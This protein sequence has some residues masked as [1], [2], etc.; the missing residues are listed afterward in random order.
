MTEE[1]KLSKKLRRFLNISY[2][3]AVE[4]TIK[5]GKLDVNSKDYRQ[6]DILSIVEHFEV[7]LDKRKSLL[8]GKDLLVLNCFLASLRNTV[9]N[10]RFTM[11]AT[12]F[13]ERLTDFIMYI[14]IWLNSE[15]NFNVD[16]KIESRRKSLE[17]ELTK[18]LV[19]SIEHVESNDIILST[20][21]PIIRDRYGLRIIM[22]DDNPKLLLEVTGIIISILTNPISEAHI[23]FKK[24]ML[25]IEARFGGETVP[26]DDLVKM[27]DY[28]FSLSH[29]KDYVNNPKPSTYQ[30]WHTTLCID[31][32]S[33]NLG[34]L[35][36]ELQTRTWAMHK[37]A[38]KGP[39]SHDKYKELILDYCD[40]FKIKNY[41]GGIVFYDGPENPDLDLDGLSTSAHPL[42][43]HIS[44]H[45]I[46]RSP[47][48]T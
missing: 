11:A 41:S 29:T 48:H 10:R 13:I 1:K 22:S 26:K 6:P 5:A 46:E 27:L 43:R 9:K 24:W 17:G 38:I 35:M 3:M 8:T 19:K 23:E 14:C 40:I 30:S 12:S 4:D 47:I 39:A 32:T 15:K 33:P 25:T 44:P 2:N 42:S 20:Q 36:F 18:I 37:N 7:V 34:G 45:V 21:P 31:A 16:L 28:T